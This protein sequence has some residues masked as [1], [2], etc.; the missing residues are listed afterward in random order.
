MSDKASPAELYDAFLDI[1]KEFRHILHRIHDP[2][3][4]SYLKDSIAAPNRK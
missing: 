4:Y 2:R 3:F 1:S